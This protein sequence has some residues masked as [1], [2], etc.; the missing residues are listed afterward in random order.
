MAVGGKSRLLVENCLQKIEE[1]KRLER[2]R[3]AY[4]WRIRAN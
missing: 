1:R 2:G 4:E 3:D